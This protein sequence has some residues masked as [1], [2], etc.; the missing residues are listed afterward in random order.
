MLMEEIYIILKILSECMFFVVIING[1]VN[2]KVIGI[3][4]Y[5]DDIYCVNLF[6]FMKFLLFMFE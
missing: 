2:V 4:I 6:C 1:N 5:F 3:D